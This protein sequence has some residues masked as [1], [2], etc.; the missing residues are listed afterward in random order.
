MSAIVRFARE[1]FRVEHLHELQRGMTTGAEN[2]GG[3]LVR[4]D[5]EL[6]NRAHG[7]WCLAH[8]ACGRGGSKAAGKH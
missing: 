7:W 1:D 5:N 3:S 4:V 2:A 6:P 8:C